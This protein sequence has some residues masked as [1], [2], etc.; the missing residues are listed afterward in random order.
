MTFNELPIECKKALLAY[1]YMR[2]Q[3]IEEVAEFYKE[4]LFKL[5]T[6]S[7]EEAK[8]RCIEQSEDWYEDETFEAYHQVYVGDGSTIPNHGDSIFPVIEGGFGEWLDD[9]WH[10][11]HSYVKNGHSTIPVLRI[12]HE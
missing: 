6:I 7:M 2:F 9:G 12:I 1:C 10:R 5:E 3:T 4:R 11:F 8:K